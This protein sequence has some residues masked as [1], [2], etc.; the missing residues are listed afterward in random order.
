MKPNGTARIRVSR[1]AYANGVSTFKILSERD[2]PCRITPKRIAIKDHKFNRATLLC[3]D[4]YRDTYRY[5]L[6]SFEANMAVPNTLIVEQTSST[7]P[8]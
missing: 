7:T 4:A 3:I 5:E 6:L 8:P 1:R 2:E